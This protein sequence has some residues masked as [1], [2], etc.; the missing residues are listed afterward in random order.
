MTP[1]E[2]LNFW[3]NHTLVDGC[4]VENDALRVAEAIKDY[5]EDL[6]LIANVRPDHPGEPPWLVLEKCKDGITR[7]VLSAWELND[8]ILVRL[9]SADGQR[10][11]GLKTVEQTEADV[12]KEQTR[13]FKEN[14]LEAHDVA[15]SVLR[16]K[17]SKYTVRDS[18]TGELLTFYDDRP[19]TR[20]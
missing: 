7:P 5:C 6:I 15:A 19:A 4:I 14:M 17:K 16:D 8:M 18:R 10:F 20:C 13:R 12:K 2:Q 9:Q 11:N 3:N 1:E